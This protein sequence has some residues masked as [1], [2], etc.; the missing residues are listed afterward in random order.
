MQEELKCKDCEGIFQ[1]SEYHTQS[2][3][4]KICRNSHNKEKKIGLK[5]EELAEYLLLKSCQN[6]LDRVRR[7]QKPAYQ[8]VKCSWNK[9]REMKSEIMGCAAFWEEWK[10]QSKIYEKSERELSFRPTIDRIESDVEKGGHYYFGNIAVLPY[11]KNSFKA[12]AIKC[13]VI[14]FEGKRM[15]KAVD[16]DSIEQVMR[17]LEIPSYNSINI[18]R[19][20]GKI[21]YVGN[22]Y[23]VLIQ[24]VGGELKKADKPLYKMVIEK[25][26][27]IVDSHTGKEY[28]WKRC[29]AS[30]YTDGLWF[31]VK[32]VM[33]K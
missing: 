24:T 6:V 25:K 1:S 11:S 22:G 10:K 23:S 4:C 17:D 13:W 19:D 12:N 15:L 26:L 27:F 33:H 21:S 9:P 32:S 3:R 20:S 30:Y 31:N 18:K 29:Q 14:F 8:G 7:N 5:D 16:Y 2:K 28:E